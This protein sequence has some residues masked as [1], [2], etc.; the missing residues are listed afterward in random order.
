MSP[1][2]I[3]AHIQAKQGPCHS[4]APPPAGTSCS[5]SPWEC[6]NALRSLP[7]LLVLGCVGLALPV[8]QGSLFARCVAAQESYL[9]SVLKRRN[10]DP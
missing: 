8:T 9:Q 2:L 6:Y 1:A 4:Q 5:L 10:M 7:A 3:P